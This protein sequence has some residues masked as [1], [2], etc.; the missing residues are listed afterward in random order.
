MSGAP[1]PF[2]PCGPSFSLLHYVPGTP[3]VGSWELNISPQ[4]Q[5]KDNHPLPTGGIVPN[6]FNFLCSFIIVEFEV[7]EAEVFLDTRAVLAR[8]YLV[9]YV[10]LS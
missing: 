1:I 5:R 3:I 8:C 4:V 9:V 10:S 6:A 2:K 7:G